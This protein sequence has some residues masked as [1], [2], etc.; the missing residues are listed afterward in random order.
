M[1]RVILESAPCVTRFAGHNYMPV[2][3]ENFYYIAAATIR[4]GR[5][6]SGGTAYAIGLYERVSARALA[7]SSRLQTYN[8]F[9]SGEGSSNGGL[10]VFV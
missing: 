10:F 9:S 4:D 8:A 5:Q 1:G 6:L 3:H 2:A 7:L